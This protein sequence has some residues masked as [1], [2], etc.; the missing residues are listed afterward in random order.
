MPILPEIES[1]W[2]VHV[3]LAYSKNHPK[4]GKTWLTSS[5]MCFLGHSLIVIVMREAWLISTSLQNFYMGG[6]I[7]NRHEFKA[8]KILVKYIF[9]IPYHKISPQN[10]GQVCHLQERI[11]VWKTRE[12]CHLY[13]HTK[14][15]EEADVNIHSNWLF[16]AL[17]IHNH[18][19]PQHS[20]RPYIVV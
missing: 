9:K 2:R 16:E 17:H 12:S 18:V 10:S 6:S 11:F 5:F 1:F 20:F 14:E 3:Q 19:T 8:P 15:E 13:T 7:Y 4:R